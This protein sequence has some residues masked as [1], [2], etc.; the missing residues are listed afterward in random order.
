MKFS[1]LALALS[2]W[3]A[4][5]GSLPTTPPPIT[6]YTSF[7]HEHSDVVVKA[8]ETELASIMKPVGVEIEWRSLD[9]PN[10]S[11][12][13]AE[14][15]V[16]TF[17][18][19]C[20]G[21]LQALFPPQSAG[22]GWT[23]LSDG[24]ILPFAEVDCD[25]MRTLVQSNLFRLPAADRA[26]AFGRAMA[27]V[28]AHELYHILARTMHH[29]SGISKPAYSAQELLADEFVFDSRETKTLR[30]PPRSTPARKPAD[31]G[32]TATDLAQR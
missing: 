22:L 25:R 27:R 18:G 6:I 12:V 15:V 7:Q 28:T 29:G 3:P 17:H 16:L 26:A 30:N 14:I 19:S 8:L 21:Q 20:D 2:V 31:Q 13:A 11:R 23:H 4:L 1:I 32:E 24:E 10:D 5:G 9:D